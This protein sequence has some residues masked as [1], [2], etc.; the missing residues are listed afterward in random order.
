MPKEEERLLGGKVRM[1][2]RGS[3]RLLHDFLTPS[4]SFGCGVPVVFLRTALE[5]V[6]AVSLLRLLSWLRQ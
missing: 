5:D 6:D 3:D 2:A 1:G 4:R